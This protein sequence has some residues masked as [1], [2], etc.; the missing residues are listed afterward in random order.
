MLLWFKD[1]VTE[2]VTNHRPNI[3]TL[4]YSAFIRGDLT[5]FI[6]FLAMT[7]IMVRLREHQKAVF[8]CRK[9][10]IQLCWST[11]IKPTIQL[12]GIGLKLSPLIDV[13]TS[14]FAWKPGISTPT[15]LC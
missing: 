12:G 11:H 7:V 2:E 15:M 9:M 4:L 3:S 13:T 14:T 6:L 5:L 10:K 8:F 1:L